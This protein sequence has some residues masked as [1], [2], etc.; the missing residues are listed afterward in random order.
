[1]TVTCQQVAEQQSE[2]D[3]WPTQENTARGATGNGTNGLRN[4]RA[5]DTKVYYLRL[6]IVH[7][8]QYPNNRASRW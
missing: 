4:P 3:T 1:M 5:I 7:Q 2:Q 6:G 8:E